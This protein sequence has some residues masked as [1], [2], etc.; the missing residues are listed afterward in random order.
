[1][2]QVNI[3]TSGV[4]RAPRKRATVVISTPRKRKQPKGRK[5]NNATREVVMVPTTKISRRQRRKRN[6]TNNKV[7]NGHRMNMYN[8]LRY[9]KNTVTD[10]I[11]IMKTIHN[12]S[13]IEDT[14]APRREK[15]SNIIGTTSTTLSII[16]QLYLNPGN[17]VLFPIFSQIADTYEQ[18]RVNSL[19][20]SYETEAYA[21]S[22]TNVS[23]GKVILATNYDPADPVFSTDTQMENYFNSDRGA[24]YCEIIHDAIGGDHALKDEASKAYYV[25]KSANLIAPTSDSTGGKFYD[26][27]NFQLGCQGNA[28]SSAEIGELYVTYSFTM[29]RPKQQLF[30]NTNSSFIHYV[31]SGQTT[32]APYLNA[33]I[34]AGSSNLGV[35][36][37]SGQIL[38]FLQ[39]GRYYM[40]YVSGSTSS[41]FVSNTLGAGISPVTNVGGVISTSAWLTGTGT[42]QSGY[43]QWFDVTSLTG[44]TITFVNTV[45][46][47]TFW[48]LIVCQVPTGFGESHES[49]QNSEIDIL[50]KDVADLRSLISQLTISTSEPA[51]PVDSGA[52]DLTRSV[53]IPRS[54]VTSF[55]G[56]YLS[57]SKPNGDDELKVQTR[58]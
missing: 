33:T 9:G 43:C 47:G 17:S 57:N 32:A 45:V 27:G 19:F 38:T 3:R 46:T 52:N 5:A 1:M 4:K 23:A 29:I 49:K 34:R 21:A 14:F 2:S 40:N 36:S 51:T 31:G 16:S 10:G 55:L 30:L 54:V 7:K 11:S 28:S 6:N 50:K 12:S 37:F 20:F 56:S 13:V 24:P 15:V 39:L 48:D 22:G 58:K 26:I 42:N 41:T 35:F 18:Y 53:H 25:N 44:A 8:M